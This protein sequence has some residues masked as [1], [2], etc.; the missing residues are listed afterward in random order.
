MARPGAS[1]P[2]LEVRAKVLARQRGYVDRLLSKSQP[3]RHDFLGCEVECP[4]GAPEPRF[5]TALLA[6]V[7]WRVGGRRVLDTFSGHGAI[8]AVLARCA[9][10]VVA[11][12]IDPACV[13]AAAANAKRNGQAH[14]VRAV[15]GDV[16]PETPARFDLIVA[17]PPY[18]DHDVGRPGDRIVWD[19]AHASVR[20]LIG[21]AAARLAANG[22]LVM[23]WPNY[24]PLDLV[25]R[26]AH[27]DRLKARV[28]AT[29][30]DP[31][32]LGFDDIPGG[33]GYNIVLISP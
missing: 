18:S 11:C 19:P 12:D 28:V 9:D 10:E 21:A 25:L 33:L 22:A 20:K 13:A 5:D 6:A 14:K 7:A 27:A 24:E 29:A 16:F 30:S 8:A 23:S 1:A 31:D 2:P 3:S 17:N 32:T 15:L 26:C 4:P